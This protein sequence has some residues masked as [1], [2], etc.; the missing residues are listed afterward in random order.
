MNFRLSVSLVSDRSLSALFHIAIYILKQF[1][2]RKFHQLFMRLHIATLKPP[3]DSK[4]IGGISTY[5]TI[6][7]QR[8]FDFRTDDLISFIWLLISK[9]AS[10]LA[11]Q[12][13]VICLLSYQVSA[14]D[15]SDSS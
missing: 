2:N 6:T 7:S 13:C 14:H 11:A 10:L 1:R 5:D 12:R 9:R 8:L 15:H 3:L 4:R